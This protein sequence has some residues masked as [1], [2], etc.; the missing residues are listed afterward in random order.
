MPDPNTN[1]TPTSTDFL[2]DL[3]AAYLQTVEAGGV[4]D[5]R[6]LLDRYPEHAPALA[7]FFADLDRMDRVAAPLRID[8]E[9][10]ETT[11][12][13]GLAPAHPPTVRYFGDYELL[14]EIARGGMG[15]VYKARQTSLNR[16][17]ALKMILAGTF[18][19]AREVARFQAE[20][21]ANLDHPQIVPVYEVGEQDGQQ[22]FSMKYIEGGSL[23][24]HPR[25]DPRAEVLGLIAI[26]RAVHHAHQHGVL[27]RDL[28]PS[29]VLVD[30][31][32]GR[33]VTDF[34]L[35]KR[36]GDLD[37]SL[38]EAGQVLGT[39]RYMSPEQA[40][41]RKDLTV[42]TDIYALGVIF[43]ER[44][45]GRTP[46]DGDNIVT[47]L[48]QVRESAPPRPSSILP[49]LDRDL[50]TVALKCLDKDP[51]R[52]YPTAED[53]AEDLARWLAG[54]PI[55]ARPVGQAER[56]TRWCRRNPVVASLSASVVTVSLLGTVASTTFAL[57]ERAEAGR[58]KNA[59]DAAVAARDDTERTLARSLGRAFFVGITGASESNPHLSKPEV[60]SLWELASG[61]S[62]SVKLRS[63]DESLG[64]PLRLRQLRSRS[65]P[66]LIAALGLDLDRQ[67]EVVKRMCERMRSEKTP[68]FDRGEVANLLLD[69]GIEAG[70]LA[71]EA[72]EIL[73]RVWSDKPPNPLLDESVAHAYSSSE[74]RDPTVSMDGLLSVIEY[75]Q[76]RVDQKM[77]P[78][79]GMRKIS[80]SL[81]LADVEAS[82]RRLA[83]A[84]EHEEST[85]LLLVSMGET[86]AELASRID[87]AEAKKFYRTSAQNLD[88][89]IQS[90]VDAHQL[91][92]QTNVQLRLTAQ[93]VPGEASAFYENAL[94]VLS[95]AFDRSA[96]DYRG[97]LILLLFV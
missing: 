75:R 33:H 16:L 57:R 68:L 29:N 85:S 6:A 51:T 62:N 69:T 80:A 67:T 37:R 27:H 7:A 79:I 10:D 24:H 48:R 88:R 92:V 2:D 87:P 77:F 41:G 89:E 59:E 54:R 22:Y 93:L 36:L 49:G 46:F 47:L 20:A 55:T 39:P 34:G 97:M 25:A 35:A 95:V 83:A 4:P 56:F 64:D 65:G 26:A 90:E 50:E 11:P 21:A 18:A 40:A 74:Y 91:S 73:H 13:D 44:L 60:E 86:M 43:Y 70:P 15:I 30:P 66:A 19:T 81:K 78:L 96:E 71:V 61:V 38:T 5:R 82:A 3:I 84:I 28:K 12:V 9:A 53:L 45:T 94:R 17:V 42:A 1:P 14:E 8:A 23:A 58:A 63:I 76:F 52:R 32:G 72:S 31:Q